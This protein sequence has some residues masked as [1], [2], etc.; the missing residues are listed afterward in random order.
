MRRQEGRE[1]GEKRNSLRLFVRNDDD[2]EW[3]KVSVNN[4]TRFELAMDMV[5]IGMSFRQT[6]GAIQ[7]TR[8]RT[9]QAILSGV[10]DQ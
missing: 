2:P 6:A 10:S 7:L 8:E 5:S 3:Y 9:K 1:E 4:A